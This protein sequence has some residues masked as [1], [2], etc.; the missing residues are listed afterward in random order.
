LTG[1]AGGAHNGR[2]SRLSGSPPA[3]RVLIVDDD[4]S[5]TDTFSRMLRLDGHE[6]WAALSAREGLKLAETHRP[7]AVI[8]DLRSPLA[9]SMDLVRTLKAM[10]HLARTPMAVVSGDYYSRPD[11][12]AELRTLGVDLR[13]KPLWLDE[14]VA[15]ARRLLAVS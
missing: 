15:L 2:V 12:V 4:S 8:V 13:F 11:H 10:P 5:V 7:T 3:A 14:L 6:V 1:F 9:T